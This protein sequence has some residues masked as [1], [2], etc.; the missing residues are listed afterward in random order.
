MTGNTAM[1]LWLDIKKEYI[2]ENFDNVISYLHKRV[3]NTEL[4]D[5]FYKTTLSLL[6]ARIKSLIET[7]TSSPLQEDM[8]KDEELEIVC[9]MCGLYLLVFGEDSQTRRNAFSLML[10][11]LLL[12]SHKNELK[13]AELAV[14]NLLGRVGAKLPFGW[15]D[16]EE[17]NP[18]ILA[19]KI[20]NSVEVADG[21]EDEYRF[22]DKGSI[23]LK[24]GEL[25]LSALLAEDPSRSA[26]VSAIDVMGSHLQILS[27][28]DGKIKKSDTDSLPAM[29]EF[30]ENFVG[31]LKE[32]APK[33]PAYLKQYENGDCA[34]VVITRKESASK[35][36]ARTVDKDHEVLEGR[37]DA[38]SL[39]NVNF[40]IN[41]FHA[42]LNEGDHIYVTVSDVTKA[43]F[44][45]GYEFKSYI[46]S[47]RTEIG[48]CHCAYINKILT[49]RGNR[50]KAY[51]WTESGF[52]AQA[53]VDPKKD[54]YRE[55]SYVMIKVTEFGENDYFGV[56]MSE[57]QDYSEDY[58]DVNAAKANC[59]ESY[60]LAPEEEEKVNVLE[61]ETLRLMSRIMLGYQKKL[62]RPSDRY[63]LLCFMRIIA[64]MTR[65]E[66]DAKY[67]NFVSDYMEALVHFA[68]GDYGKLHPLE[69]GCEEEPH[70]VARRKRVVEIL[71][72]YG[73]DD[74][75]EKL[76]EIIDEDDDELI[77]KIAIL[78]LSCNRIDHVI[79]KSMQNVIKR[80]IIKCL[81]IE[82]E[83]D[84]NL[85]DEN[86]TYLGIENDRQEFKTSFFHAP[87]DAREQVQKRTIL[88]GVCA[89]LNTRVGGTLYLGVDDLG[90]IKGIED[91][92]RY[93]ERYTSGCYKGMDGYVR[94]IT[95]EAKKVFDLSV[96]TNVRITP[97][98]D[99]QVVAITVTP[100][101]YA[102]VKVDDE[103]FIRINSET[104]R[105]PEP[106]QQQIMAQKILSKK[107]DAAN[108]GTLMGAVEG[109]RKVILHGYSSSHSGEIR[110]RIVEPF[111]F[112]HNH[113]TVWCY[114][115]EKKTNK[116][117]KVDRISN[118]EILQENWEYE[119]HHRKGN[120]DIFRM[121]GETP[122]PV[123]LELTLLARNILIEE[124]PEAERH[125]IP[126]NNDDRWLL[127]TDV[128]SLTGIGR[129]YIGLAGEISIISAPGLLKY[130]QDYCREHLS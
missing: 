111:A 8:C 127:E 55:G 58:F 99:N 40:Y 18:E 69:F 81:A 61:I 106:M 17:L 83:G 68:K 53:Y 44:D 45:L 71:Q 73:D 80:E 24:N 65:N 85:E 90:Y 123:K 26:L 10:Q 54:N 100:Y 14:A 72:A 19:H 38:T 103:A 124:Y 91:D 37:L 114:D 49:D 23:I 63:R 16:I 13:L 108:V 113:K 27:D 67:I 109:K 31:D 122:I 4:Q 35:I 102:I 66:T 98:Y 115:L 51:M 88:R 129:F 130:A 70:S 128:Y 57:I 74:Q 2:D 52:A 86:G 107:E 116:V 12:L 43:T 7:I 1:P 34:E 104:I 9:R 78:V 105:M 25:T 110:D 20:V 119:T 121:T 62:P 3:K 6:E 28:K 76:S 64:E 125:L 39:K 89:F 93:M 126:T 5:S 47:Y 112:G 97:M 56:V 96:M 22:E 48:H 87:K 101:E 92:I 82:A 29:A 21:L 60:C 30:T 33:G 46:T 50:V 94:Y 79:S 117:F 41:D 36:W 11:S 59:I 118:V 32:S 77:H 42:N 75:N 15:E 120:M 95:D 84:T